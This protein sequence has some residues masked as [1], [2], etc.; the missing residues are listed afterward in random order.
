MNYAT[1]EEMLTMTREQ[2]RVEGGAERV[3]FGG[4]CPRCGNERPHMPDPPEVFAF[5][6]PIMDSEGIW[7]WYAICPVT[8]D[9]WFVRALDEADM[10]RA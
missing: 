6:R 9:P 10:P 5:A 3:D 1:P 8:G 7:H 4:P 2:R